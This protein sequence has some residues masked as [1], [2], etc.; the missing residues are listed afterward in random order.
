MIWYHTGTF[1]GSSGSPV[2]DD[3]WNVVA[4]H[5]GASPSDA[6][7]ETK[8]M[9]S[10]VNRGVSTSAILADVEARHPELAREIRAAGARL[11]G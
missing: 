10:W 5:C 8:R 3:R 11:Q 6:V 9:T 4:I 1:A 2:C 7:P